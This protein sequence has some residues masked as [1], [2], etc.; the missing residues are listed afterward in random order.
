M[1]LSIAGVVLTFI[2]FL[3]FWKIKW[4]AALF[5]SYSILVPISDI[6][7][8]PLHL[9][10]NA[11]NLILILA[12]LYNFKMKHRYKLSW[13]LIM[14]FIFYYIIE[15]LIIPFQD[16]TPISWMYNSW[17]VSMMSTLLGAFFLYN[18]LA[19][20]PD[21]Q[22]IIRKSLLLSIFVAGTYGLFL[23][24]LGG[25]NPYIQAIVMLKGDSSAVDDL[26]AYFTAE[27]QGRMFGRI[28]SVF[29]HPMSFGLF[30]GI[31]FIYVFA[32]RKIINKYVFVIL[33]VI[34]SLNALFCGVRSCIGA[35]VVAVAF[36]LLFSKN[37]KIAV[38]T[39]VV[40][41]IAY[42]L[43][44][45]MPE[46]SDYVSSIADI[47]NENSYVSGSSIE[48][49]MEQLKGCFT[50]IRNSPILGKGYS[51]D[52]WYKTNYGDH[53]AIL[54]FESMIFVILCDNGL[55][56]F[57]IWG[58]FIFLIV[59]NNKRFHLYDTAIANSLLIYYLSYSCITGEYGYMQYF[60]LFYI[61]L[62]FADASI[63]LQ[64]LRA[65]GKNDL[66]YKCCQ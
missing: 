59:R 3:C 54:S 25:L 18:V 32:I 55:L 58:I 23:T 12:L 42:N 2:L 65:N 37:V 30:I 9:G 41:L 62:I 47:H 24:T 38:T 10:E 27:G 28:S 39:L 56:G 34:L 17:R 40:G 8:G 1:I 13:K 33:L 26:L 61:C 50:E 64:N 31:A 16:G 29:L 35:L 21:S 5:L 51:W 4:G 49:R 19:K 45:K 15:L 46:L 52:M 22:D 57:V 36:Y 43:I 48:M 66:S 11:V 60:L 53:P 14:P 44:L 7:L 20:Y 6:T 63:K